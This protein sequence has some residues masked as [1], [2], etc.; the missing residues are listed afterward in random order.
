MYGPTEIVCAATINEC[1]QNTNLSIGKPLN[2]YRAYVLNN[3]LKLIPIGAIG[4]LYIGGAGLARGYLNKPELT[5]E[6]FIPNP[7]QT[8]EEKKKGKNSRIY[9]TGDL[10]RWLPDGNIDYIGRNDFQ[11]KIRGFRIELEEIESVLLEY[12]GIKQSVVLAKERKKD[13]D[14]SIKYLVGYY[15]SEIKLDELKIMNH[16]K[17]KLAEYMVP[18]LLIHLD[19]LPITINGNVV[20]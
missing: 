5:K 20:Q 8:D 13:N 11:V 18:S 16:L 7:F 14:E 15:V 2:N 19:K 1:V 17:Q 4:E 9:K 6:K 10:V 3:E 12:E